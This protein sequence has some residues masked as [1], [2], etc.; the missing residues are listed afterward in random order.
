VLSAENLSF[1]FE[2][3]H[4]LFDGLDWE[5]VPGEIFCLLGPSG[6][7]KS[8]L[9]RLLVGLIEPNAG[10][11]AFEGRDL[12]ELSRIERRDFYRTLGFTFQRNGL[13]D[14]LSCGDN[15]RFPLTE[16]KELGAEERER[17]VRE[18]L[19][20]VGLSGQESLRPSEMS[21]GMQKR[22]GI[23]RALSLL[24]KLIFYDEPTA[25]LD[26]LTSAQILDLI[27][28]ARK[29]YSMSAVVST[30]DPVQAFRLAD[31]I[32][33]LHRGKLAEVG[34]PEKFRRSQ[35]PAVRQFLSGGAEGPLTEAWS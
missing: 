19:S 8:V 16:L 25:G 14:S 23:A 1:G 18:A 2:P 10:R 5:L 34:S 33:F 28:S 30:T 22:L 17:R 24:P 11:V 21:G 9:L 27:E 26:P 32:G 6:E 15:L 29:K 13:F 31:R 3:G 20:D 35:H 4:L 12:R 7:G